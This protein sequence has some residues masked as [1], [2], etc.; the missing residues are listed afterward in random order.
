L[1]FL[2]LFLDN[3]E[4]ILERRP[5]GQGFRLKKGIK[6]HLFISTA[7]C[8]DARIFSPKE[9]QVSSNVLKT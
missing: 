9:E 4:L 2:L 7:P 3:P 1:P 6:T 8:G 5:D